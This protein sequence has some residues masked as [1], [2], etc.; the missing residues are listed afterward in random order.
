MKKYALLLLDNDDT[1]NFLVLC[2]KKSSLINMKRD[3]KS[4]V[5]LIT[6]ETIRPSSSL[7]KDCLTY[8]KEPR[9]ISLEEAANLLLLKMYVE[10][11]LILITL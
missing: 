9:N 1:E 10:K 11:V 5:D 4:Y 7:Y 6:G 3:V 2:E 8:S